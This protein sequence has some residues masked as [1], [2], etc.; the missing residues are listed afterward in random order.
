MNLRQCFD[1]HGCDRGYRHGYERVYEQLFAPMRGSELHILEIGIFKGAGIAAWL[2][3]FPKAF[4]FAIDTFERARPEDIPVLEHGRVG[5]QKCDST[6]EQALGM[7]DLVF[8][9]G[10]HDPLSQ[11]LTLG[12]QLPNCCGLYFIED[13]YPGHHDPHD[14]RQLRI[15]IDRWGGRIHNLRKYGAVDSVLAEIPC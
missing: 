13:I 4:V 14:E 10:A 15:S 6:K 11:R 8:D 1:K 2:D 12:K 9:D 5:W 7:F 3:Y